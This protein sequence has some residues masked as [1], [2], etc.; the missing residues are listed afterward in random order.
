[1]RKILFILLNGLAVIGFAVETKGGYIRYYYS[2]SGKYSFQLYTWTNSS[3]L[4]SDLCDINLYLDN[5]DSIPCQ[6]IN[7][8]A[9]CPSGG[10][11]FDGVIIAP[12]VKENVYQST[13][14]YALNPG[15]HV[16]TYT[17]SN[18]QAGI[19]NL[20][21]SSSQNIA[22][23][24]IDTFY[25]YAVPGTVN[26]SPQISYRPIDNTVANHIFQ[27]DPGMIDPEN[28]SLDFTLIR[29][30]EDDPNNPPY[31]LQ[32]I[33]SETIPAGLTID[34][35]TGVLTWNLVTN[36]QG[37]YDI[38]ILIK[39]Y[40]PTTSINCA[41]LL[42]CQTVLD[43]PMHVVASSAN[44]NITSP[45]QSVCIMAGTTFTM[46]VNAMTTGATTAPVMLSAEGLPFSSSTLGPHATFSIT[47]NATSAAGVFSWQTTY[48]AL[49]ANAYHIAIRASDSASPAN[50]AYQNWLIKVVPPPPTNLL[51]T[52]TG[53]TV[54]LTWNPPTNY[55]DSNLL[56][57]NVYRSDSCMAYSPAS[58]Q[59]GAPSGILMGI[60]LNSAGNNMWS[61]NNALPGT[62]QYFVFPV[63]RGCSEG[64]AAA[65]PCVTVG[66][67]EKK[68]E[69]S[70]V[71]FPN[72]YPRKIYYS[73]SS[74]ASRN[75]RGECA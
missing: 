50:S 32:Q 75:Y 30:F 29:S 45:M 33:A 70:M 66:I 26:S 31:G 71:V 56:Q 2:G 11:G 62:H 18:R 38:S 42:V 36:T 20:G 73:M 22:F 17:T 4:A 52:A 58:C 46:Q 44:V 6:R 1:M 23:A 54:H 34:Q 13:S 14:S 64:L 61:D 48:H 40:K 8:T 39:E 63:F 41:R 12:G 3:L 35:K 57:F 67:E 43:M 72:P 27:Y 19:I 16:I 53:G 55:A 21:G 10:S 15:V 49:H 7:G 28:D 47:S 60:T 51:A 25:V 5:T 69:T 74:K 9:P 59:T 24:L 68:D 37:D 65:T